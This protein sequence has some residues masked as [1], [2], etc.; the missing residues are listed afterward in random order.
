MPREAKLYASSSGPLQDY[1]LLLLTPFHH[2]VAL[3]VLLDRDGILHLQ[4]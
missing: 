4:T 1:S 3:P 2:F